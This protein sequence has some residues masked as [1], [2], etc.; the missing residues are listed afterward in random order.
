MELAWGEPITF[1]P[2]Q[3]L[4]G[5]SLNPLYKPFAMDPGLKVKGL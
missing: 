4:L 3:K 2:D 5:V 1:L